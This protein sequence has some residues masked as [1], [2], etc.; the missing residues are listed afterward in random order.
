MLHETVAVREAVV[1]PISAAP[2]RHFRVCF[3]G[4]YSR[5][6]PPYSACGYQ[7]QKE[8][9]KEDQATDLRYRIKSENE[10]HDRLMQR[11]GCNP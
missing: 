1:E 10:A 5:E 6:C 2:F 4:Y 7:R 9:P 11:L 3:Q 8:M